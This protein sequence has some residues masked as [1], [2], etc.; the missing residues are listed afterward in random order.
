M[1]MMPLQ[2]NEQELKQS[3]KWV[4]LIPRPTME[5]IDHIT[6]SIKKHGQQAPIIVDQNYMIMDGYTRYKICKKLGLRVK[7]TVKQFKDDEE[8]TDFIMIANVERRHLKAFDRVRL[9]RHIYDEMRT[10]AKKKQINNLRGL[11]GLKASRADLQK[12][13]SIYKFA[14]KIGVSEGTAARAMVVLDEGKKK[15][16]EM[17]E[18]GILSITTMYHTIQMRKRRMDEQQMPCTITI[19]NK[20]TDNTK[21]IEKRLTKVLYDNLIGYIERL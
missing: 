4:E 16:V 10:E 5:E 6:A 14:K 19:K 12:N 15:E 17:V 13:R 3:L 11:A 18:K 7:Y 9:F 8:R 2:Q 21:T 1:L 20:Y